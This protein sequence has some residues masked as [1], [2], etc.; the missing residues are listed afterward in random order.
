M[1]AGGLLGTFRKGTDGRASMLQVMF[2]I[3][4]HMTQYSPLILVNYMPEVWVENYSQ[5]RQRGFVKQD[6]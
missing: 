4:L 3:K 5:G 2:A 6:V 1:D